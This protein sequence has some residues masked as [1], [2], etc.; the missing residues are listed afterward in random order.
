[1]SRRRGYG[2]PA[3]LGA[4]GAF[5]LVSGVVR[6]LAIDGDPWDALASITLGPAFVAFTA[7]ALPWRF[8]RDPVHGTESVDGT[9][10]PAVIFLLRRRPLAW[11]TAASALLVL[12]GVWHVA[13][14]LTA[15]STLSTLIGAV[16]IVVFG[17]LTSATAWRLRWAQRVALT[18][19]LVRFRVPSARADLRWEDIAEFDVRTVEGIPFAVLRL[20]ERARAKM[21]RSPLLCFPDRV[22]LDNELGGD[23]YLAADALRCRFGLFTTAFTMY[24]HAPEERRLIGRTG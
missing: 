17:V 4:V 22:R 23:I 24:L 9:E 8:D 2:L 11:G 15:P 12:T 14:G 21:S 3:G 5:C 7:A 1:M 20:H 19:D 6:D 10:V 13:R 16:L 18:P